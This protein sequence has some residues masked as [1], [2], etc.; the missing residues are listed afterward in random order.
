MNRTSPP[1]LVRGGGRRD[2]RQI[3]MRARGTTGSVAGPITTA[4]S[5]PIVSRRPA[6]PGSPQAPCPGARTLREVRASAQGDLSEH[7]H[8][9]T[10]LTVLI[11]E[12]ILRPRAPLRHPSDA[13][14]EQ[15]RR[16][17]VTGGLIHEYHA[18]AACWNRSFG[19]LQGSHPR[20]GDV[21]M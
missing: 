5:R 8:A 9:G 17:N 13:R 12:S 15:V 7:F 3:R 18:V 16:R 20:P 10:T 14:T 4:G 19:P 6:R 2:E 11:A 1:L 21:L